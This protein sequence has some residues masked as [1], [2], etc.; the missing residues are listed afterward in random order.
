MR[1]IHRGPVNS[2]HK[3]PVMRKM[4][5]FDDVIMFPVIR[6]LDYYWA[7]HLSKR[8]M[9][10]MMTTWSLTHWGRDEMDQ[11]FAD[12]I[13]KRIFLKQNVWNSFKMRLKFAPKGLINNIPVLVQI[14]AWRRT[15]EKPLSEPM[16]VSLPTHMCVTRPQWVNWIS[17][18]CKSITLWKNTSWNMP[19]YD[20]G[21]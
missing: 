19:S 3:G 8:L 10:G 14:M 13:F 21:L 16:M 6:L 20:R 7:I 11:H 5:P 12:D 9:A 1:G 4:F 15:G 2:P 17:L 18:P